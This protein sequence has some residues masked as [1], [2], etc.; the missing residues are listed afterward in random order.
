M[1]STARKQVVRLGAPQTGAE[2]EE[3]QQ[4]RVRVRGAKFLLRRFEQ[5]FV[6]H[7][8]GRA[9]L[10]GSILLYERK[11]EVPLGGRYRARS[12]HKFERNDFHAA[13]R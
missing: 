12:V 8:G 9:E 11:G 3:Q 10:H 6:G 2:A 1:G 13:F 7:P 4:I 5:S